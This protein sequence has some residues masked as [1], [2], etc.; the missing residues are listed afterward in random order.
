MKFIKKFK[1]NLFIQFLIIN[2]T[3]L[4][5]VIFIYNTR[6]INKFQGLANPYL[7]K[8]VVLS[9]SILPNTNFYY[10]QLP[11]LVKAWRKV[12]FKSIIILV[13]PELPIKDK[14][15]LKTIEYL[16]KFKASI[17]YLR[18]I[19]KY[20]K[21][22]SLT[23]RLFVGYLNESIINDEDFIITSDS[24]LYPIEK[25][26]YLN[27]YYRSDKS[28]IFVWNAY[29]CGEFKY[30]NELFTMYPI[31]HIGTTKKN[32]RSLMKLKSTKQQNFT[33]EFIL[34]YVRNFFQQ[35]YIIREN[36]KLERADDNW[37]LDQKMI[38]VNVNKYIKLSNTKLIKLDHDCLRL[39]RHNFE[40][41]NYKLDEFCDFHSF[42]A[43]VFNKTDLLQNVYDKLFNNETNF[44]I[45]NYI[46][47]FLEIKNN[48]N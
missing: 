43:N 5:F 18:S 41:R 44:M 31:G 26:F 35:E 15:A 25:N 12:G 47:E 45:K 6:D 32:W 9:V 14:E 16:E 23:S 33:S 1:L 42:H 38:S 28:M 30:R 20:E 4:V 17:I 13:T 11:M 22:L 27:H 37:D 21:I 39:D 48:S 40:P 34:D 46:K 36:D 2:F 8:Y 24:D 7:E 19:D 3:M 29:C 10:F